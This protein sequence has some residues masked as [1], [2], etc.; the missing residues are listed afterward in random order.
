M[1]NDL[2][3]YLILAMDDWQR[4]LEQI[5]T[6]YDDSEMVDNQAAKERLLQELVD[7]RSKLERMRSEEVED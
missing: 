3:D 7:T 6:H 5:E 1:D 4:Q 2:K